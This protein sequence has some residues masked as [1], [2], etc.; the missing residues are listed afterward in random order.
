[1]KQNLKT[2]AVILA[3]AC[4]LVMSCTDNYEDLPVN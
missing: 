4:T 3:S 1:M 2:I